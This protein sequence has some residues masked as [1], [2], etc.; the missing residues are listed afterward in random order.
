MHL[1]KNRAGRITEVIPFCMG[2][3]AASIALFVALG[4]DNFHGLVGAIV[5]AFGWNIIRD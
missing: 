1:R 2:M 4:V 5:G 3:T